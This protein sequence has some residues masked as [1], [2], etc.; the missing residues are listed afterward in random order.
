VSDNVSIEVPTS[1]DWE[2]IYRVVS[3]AF[4][5]ESS[6][7]ASDAEAKVFET[8]RGLVA[9]RE[10]EIVGTAAILTRQLAIPGGAVPAAHVTLVSVAATA[11]RQGVLTRFM[12]RQ[13]DDARAAGESIAVLWASEGRIYQ[14]FGY[15][16]AATKLGL[17]IE[18][19]EVELLLPPAGGRLREGSPSDVREALVKLYDQAYAD[20]P[21]WSERAARHWDYRLADLEQWRRGGTALRAVVH[22]DEHGADGYALWRSAGR[23]ENT[24]PA[25]E[26][27]VLELVAQTPSAYVAIWRY[28]LSIDLTRTLNVWSVA[29]D[30][31][32]L[33]AISEP[34]R[35]EARLT[36]AIW[37]R[38]LDVPAALSARRYLSDVD[39]VLELTDR[40]LPTNAGRWRLTG[41]AQAA[42]CVS[43]VDEPDLVL[44]IRALGAAYL[45]GTSLTSLAGTGQVIER[46][47]GA[48][49]RVSAAFGWFREPSSMEVF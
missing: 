1:E 30:E 22:E 29:P 33:S 3:H 23:W 40:H 12:Q 14:R 34:R 13:F 26:V 5:E 18:S 2:R 8:E 31:P 6:E 49:H 9:R 32:V 45:G 46:T 41:S 35:L 24:G 21:G 37:L 43:T 28:L 48:L 11:R 42:S 7:S 39:V 38:I 4:H 36:D 27:R 47:P 15:G 25:G 10:G 19:R 44:D 16:L 20:R 17:T